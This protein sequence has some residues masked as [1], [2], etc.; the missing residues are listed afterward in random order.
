MSKKASKTV[1]NESPAGG[2]DERAAPPRHHEDAFTRGMGRVLDHTQE[3]W[4]QL[5]TVLIIVAVL[6][7]AG[8]VAY[9]IA[10]GQ[11]EAA[12]NE[13]DTAETIEEMEAAAKEHPGS[14][15][16]LMRLGYACARRSAEDADREQ[17]AGAFR[18]AAD[19]AG[20]NSAAAKGIALAELGKMQYDLG[21]FEDA[22]RSF[23]AAAALEASRDF[24]GEEARW[25][26]GRCL[27]ELGRDDDARS[28]Y[29]SI[30]VA[31]SDSLWNYL[32]TYRLTQL[33]RKAFD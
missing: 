5:R 25:Y 21:Q 32:A 29:Q 4:R 26:A 30:T 31:S 3:N 11:S 23:E 27:E 13:I 19:A 14:V 15:S 18:R 10:T 7:V 1:R 24:V 33:R 20:E 6:L 28:K 17:A 12:L 22:L 8:I 9:G 2:T 16:L